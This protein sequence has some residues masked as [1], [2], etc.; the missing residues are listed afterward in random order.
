MLEVV[1]ERGR[2]FTTHPFGPD[3]DRQVMRVEY[4]GAGHDE[5]FERGG[6]KFVNQFERFARAAVGETPPLPS[7]EFSIRVA[8]A[9]ERIHAAAGV[10]FS[11]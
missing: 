7:M 6:D 9:I 4:A 11:A 8:D 10:R 2:L 1:G 3:P 5:V